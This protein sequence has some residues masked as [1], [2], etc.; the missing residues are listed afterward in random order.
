MILII[1]VCWIVGGIF[2]AALRE[3]RVRMTLNKA[4]FCVI[5]G[6]LAYLIVFT[7]MSAINLG[8]VSTLIPIANLGFIVALAISIVTRMETLTPRKSVAI[9]LAAVSIFLL[10]HVG[11]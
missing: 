11:G 1:P 10:S 7:L 2:Y 4:K 8:D 9:G 3:K 6:I 5:G